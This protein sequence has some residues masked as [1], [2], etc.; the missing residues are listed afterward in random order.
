M[1]IIIQPHP[2]LSDLQEFN[3]QP[4]IRFTILSI[5][6]EIYDPLEMAAPEMI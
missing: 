3:K 6:N 1:S 5:H 2:T 4:Q